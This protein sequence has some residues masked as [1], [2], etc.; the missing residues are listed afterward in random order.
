[1]L[2]LTWIQNDKTHLIFGIIDIKSEADKSE[3]KKEKKFFFVE[4]Q[5]LLGCAHTFDHQGEN[6]TTLSMLLQKVMYNGMPFKECEHLPLI[7]C[8]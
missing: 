5:L 4:A 6:G 1:M 7:G 3:K 2:K 8:A